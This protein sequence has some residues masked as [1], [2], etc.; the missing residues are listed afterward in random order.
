MTFCRLS[1]L[2]KKTRPFLK[3]CGGCGGDGSGIGDAGQNAD[4]SWKTGVRVTR[5]GARMDVDSYVRSL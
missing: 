2:R 4:R 1:D 5:H 3:E